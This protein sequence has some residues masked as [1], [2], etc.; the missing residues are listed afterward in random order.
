MWVAFH[1]LMTLRKMQDVHDKLNNISI[2]S[3]QNA[4]TILGYADKYL[5]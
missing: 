5:W 4:P 3:L 1:V 2:F